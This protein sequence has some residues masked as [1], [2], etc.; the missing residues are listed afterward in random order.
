MRA[1][2]LKQK[3]KPRQQGA[4]YAAIMKELGLPENT[5]TSYTD[6][7][8]QSTILEK[9]QTATT[10]NR[11]EHGR[12]RTKLRI[13][14][15][16]VGIAVGA[17]F[18]FLLFKNPKST[19][20]NPPSRLATETL[21]SVTI[22]H[23]EHEW[24]E[25]SCTTPKSCKICGL[26]EGE[27]L[28]H[29]QGV[30]SMEYDYCAAVKREFSS[31]ERCGAILEETDNIL[32]T[33]Y[34]GTHFCFSPEDFMKRL[35]NKFQAI[36]LG[37]YQAN[38]ESVDLAAAAGVDIEF[39][40][41]LLLCQILKGETII[42]NLMFYERNNI[43]LA[44]ARERQNAV[45]KIYCEFN[46]HSD[47]EDI[48]V[49]MS[50]FL[51]TCDPTLTTNSSDAMI[52]EI[53]RAVA[54]ETSYVNGGLSYTPQMLAAGG[55]GL[56]VTLAKEGDAVKQKETS[57]P[58]AAPDGSKD[59][60][61][62]IAT[63]AD[64]DNIRNDLSAYYR[65]VNDIALDSTTNFTP[66]G[67]GG[68]SSLGWSTEGGFSGTLDGDG[69]TIRGL[70][71]QSQR[72]CAGLFTTITAKGTVK[73]L[74]VS[75]N[76]ST[77][78]R[79]ENSAIAAIAGY[80]A[81]LIENCSAEVTAEGTGKY[82]MVGGIVACNAGIVRY[83]QGSGTIQGNGEYPKVGSVV[84]DQ[85]A[86]GQAISCVALAQNLNSP[87][88]V[89]VVGIDEGK[90]NLMIITGRHNSSSNGQIPTI[91]SYSQASLGGAFKHA[92]EI[93]AALDKMREY[94]INN[95]PDFSESIVPKRLTR[96]TF[97]ALTSN[98]WRVVSFLTTTK[99]CTEEYPDGGVQYCCVT[100]DTSTGDMLDLA[101]ILQTD[102]DSA[103][104]RVMNAA[105]EYLQ[106]SGQA[107]DLS[108]SILMNTGNYI[109]YLQDNE[110]ILV[111]DIQ[112]VGSLFIPTGILCELV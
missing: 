50:A 62:L 100:F 4:E 55:M 33:L 99:N 109:Y 11:K 63:E 92:H 108:K 69:H 47:S 30:P 8:V 79:S 91:H 16:I 71:I 49:T 58:I 110:L 83:C 39:P 70:N 14:L 59:N 31:C 46:S 2:Y 73:N 32:N 106:N 64:L 25:A 72:Q 112:N 76:L 27:T 51:Q 42:G 81:G 77:N 61:Y 41:D 36:S 102:A 53:F 1:C 68:F 103:K 6:T 40:G 56:Y 90:T 67:D 24:I 111:M 95:K 13:A 21:P 48:W 37:R 3:K 82:V 22:A 38:T 54:E 78:Y 23:V 98:N 12:K 93:N 28:G 94:I 17:V 5:L 43:L 29:L 75:A 96:T 45:T 87:G 89:R 20:D 104:E 34:S 84:G 101:S 74:S 19:N 80:N 9:T 15:G 60:P 10:K 57:A 105:W 52:A 35:G 26:Q 7:Q 65:L 86:N 44:D 88:R 107:A 85:K 66:I 97:S 18:T